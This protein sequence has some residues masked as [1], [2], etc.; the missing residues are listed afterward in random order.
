V[1]G[2]LRWFLTF[3]GALAVGFIALAVYLGPNVLAFVFH[4]DRRTEPFVMVHLLELTNPSDPSLPSTE[5]AGAAF[6]I[7]KD[8][9]GKLLWSARVDAI[10]EATLQQRWTTLALVR[11]PSR[12]AYVDLVTGTEYRNAG[13]VR[14]RWIARRTMLVGVEHAPRDDDA[15]TAPAT[16]PRYAARFLR[17]GSDRAEE[18]Y[19]AEWL[20]QDIA[21]VEEH[22]GTVAW[23]AHLEPLVG[24]QDA[25]YD[26]ALI[27]SFPD[28][29]ALDEWWNDPQRATLQSLER[30]MMDGELVMLLTP[31]PLQGAS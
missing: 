12:A 5:L 22:R 14:E 21:V 25:R 11:Y 19:F 29:T 27:V 3:L 4:E 16:G 15:L 30:R 31:A 8:Q 9:G 28:G 17:F 7:G 10:G 24:D 6:G 2:G 20:K 26:H 23:E 1:S 13:D 18:R